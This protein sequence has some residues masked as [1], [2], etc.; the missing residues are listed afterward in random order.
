MYCIVK[1]VKR[2]MYNCSVRRGV[3]WWWSVGPLKEM[4]QLNAVCFIK[5]RY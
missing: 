3:G 2:T 5:Q 1:K 4:F